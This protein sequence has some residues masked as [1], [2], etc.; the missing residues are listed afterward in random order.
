[1][2]G[3][4]VKENITL[5][6]L[7]AAVIGIEEASS[8]RTYIYRI[9]HSV[10]SLKRIDKQLEDLKIELSH[11]RTLAGNPGTTTKIAYVINSPEELRVKWA[12]IHVRIDVNR[13][14]R[15]FK[16]EKARKI[17]V[18][19]A[20]KITGL[21][22]LRYDT[23]ADEH[24]HS[25]NGTPSDDDY[26]GYFKEQAENLL[27]H[28]LESVDLRMSLERLLKAS[29]RVIK[30]SYVVDESA[31]GGLTKRTQRQQHKDVRDL[32]EWQYITTSSIVRTFEEAPIR[33]I[34]EMTGGHLERELST[35]VYAGDG[36]IA[37]DAD[38]YEEEID[39]VLSQLV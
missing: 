28:S 16:E 34:K 17:I 1:M 20:N 4:L 32:A 30:S 9:P 38:C 11:E 8:K 31:D 39:Y 6:G 36:I 7:T 26:Y 37:F 24:D 29:P 35:R 5:P 33:W 12:E 3:L 14:T 10:D 15:T 18:L 23:P 2:H 13:K 19:I 25:H 22:Q 21:V 27:G